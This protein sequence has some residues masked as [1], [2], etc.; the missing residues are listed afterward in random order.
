[1]PETESLEMSLENIIIKTKHNIDIGDFNLSLIT[2]FEFLNKIA[3][4]K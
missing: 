2:K 4:I 1:M 3:I